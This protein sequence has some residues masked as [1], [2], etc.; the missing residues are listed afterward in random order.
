MVRGIGSAAATSMLGKSVS[1]ALADDGEGHKFR[2][3][4][5]TLS[6]FGLTAAA[7]HNFSDGNYGAF[8]H[9]MVTPEQVWQSQWASAT[10][11]SAYTT[12]QEHYIQN[13]GGGEEYVL[14]SQQSI[15]AD[16]NFVSIP[17]GKTDSRI[18]AHFGQPFAYANMPGNLVKSMGH[19]EQIPTD[20]DGWF[21]RVPHDWTPTPE[22]AKACREHFTKNGVFISFT[23]RDL[24]WRNEFSTPEVRKA[25]ADGKYVQS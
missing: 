12:E 8:L 22:Q 10:H 13:D 19:F 15:G 1:Q 6:G 11:S 25:V 3:S 16:G 14:T 9:R 20:T 7:A 2:S 4:E 23:D 18:R 21:Q 17:T 24:G 5:M